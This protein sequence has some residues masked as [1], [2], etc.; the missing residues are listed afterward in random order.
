MNVGAIIIDIVILAVTALTVVISAKRGFMRTLIS[1]LGCVAVLVLSV[2]FSWII[3]DFVYGSF[4]R[5]RMTEKV[6][7]S[8]QASHVVG[9]SVTKVVDS[10]TEDLPKYIVNM[11]RSRGLFDKLSEGEQAERLQG[12]VKSAAVAVIDSVIEPVVTGLVQTISMIVLFILGM[13]AVRLLCRLSD[14]LAGGKM[15]GGVN[16]FLGGLIGL[17]S[18]IVFAIIIA[19]IFCFAVSSAKNGFLGVTEQTIEQTY[20]CKLINGFNPL[21]K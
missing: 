7:Q 5:P 6:E 14:R 4:V 21:L 8:L 2:V 11:A 17:P 10:A 16:S 18:G 1:S 13:I 20:L 15:L 3:S 12:G 19:W 9:D